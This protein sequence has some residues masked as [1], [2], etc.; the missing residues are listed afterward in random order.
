MILLAYG[1]ATLLTLGVAVLAFRM[2]SRNVDLVGAGGMLLGFWLFGRILHAVLVPPWAM[3]AYTIID[4]I[5]AIIWASIWFHRPERWKFVFA[6]CFVAQCVLHAAFWLAGNH[7][8]ETLYK[9]IWANNGVYILELLTVAAVG[10]WNVAVLVYRGGWGI[11][12]RRIKFGPFH[13]QGR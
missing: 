3:A 8:A 9:Y 4:P 10:G 5:G 1:I 12:R 2:E 6:C 11:A 7:S 13:P